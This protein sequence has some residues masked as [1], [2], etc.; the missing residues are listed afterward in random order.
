MNIL[1][2]A[3]GGSFFCGALF[4]LLAIRYGRYIRIKECMETYRS[5]QANSEAIYLP[6]K[7]MPPKQEES[8]YR[9]FEKQL[10][11]EKDKKDI[12][13]HEM[14][15]YDEDGSEVTEILDV[16]DLEQTMLLFE[17][18]EQTELLHS[19]EERSDGTS[20]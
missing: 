6:L 16:S 15:F 4:T 1:V 2:L 9:S 10:E 13:E 7:K 8:I 20:Q 18:K 5:I 12:S 17:E 3:A 14:S 19:R 11:T